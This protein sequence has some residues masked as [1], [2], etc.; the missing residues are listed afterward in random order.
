MIRQS[1]NCLIE[2]SERYAMDEETKVKL[3]RYRKNIELNGQAMLLIGLWTILKYI[4]INYF[5]DKTVMGLI[6]VTEEELRLW[7]GDMY[8]LLYALLGFMY[9]MYLYVGREAISFAKGHRKSIVFLI[10]AGLHWFLLFIG[11]PGYIIEIKGNLMK[12]DAILAAL[13]VDIATCYV[14]GDIIYSV[15]QVNKLLK[16]MDLSEV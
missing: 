13:I 16:G 10:F 2:G 1:E 7:G 4:I 5:G 14:L 15:L 9:L 3:R 12:L 6:E 11:I 8:V